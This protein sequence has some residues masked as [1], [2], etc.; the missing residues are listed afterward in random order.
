MKLINGRIYSN[1]K[2]GDKLIRIANRIKMKPVKLKMK[3]KISIVMP[4]YNAEKYLRESIESILLQTFKDFEFIIIDDCSTDNSLK[5]IESYHDKRIKIIR[6]RKNL[7]TSKSRNIGLKAAKG[8]YIAVM[9]ADDVSLTDRLSIQYNYLENNSH[10]F[11]TGS[12]AIFI[13]KNG[14][15]IKKFR[16]YD[17]YKM[18]AWRLPKS[19][20]IVHSSVMFRNTKEIFYKEYYK[21]AHDYDLYLELLSQGKN[22]TNLPQ[23]LVKHREHSESFHNVNSRQEYYSKRTQ[24]EH[25]HLNIKIGLLTKLK[26]CIKLGYFFIRTYRE[27]RGK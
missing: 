12:S 9:D 21:S 6:N 1:I 24:E 19:C 11:L 16:K 14:R 22:L 23:F 3:P 15:E 5:I 18:L 25:N 13:D 10:I 27:K 20:G 4:V 2:N 7:G 8:K 26:Y 17:D